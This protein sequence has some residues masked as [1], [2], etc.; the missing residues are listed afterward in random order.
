MQLNIKYKRGYAV[1]GILITLVITAMLFMGIGI[2][3]GSLA[4]H[5]PQLSIGSNAEYAAVMA[6][7]SAIYGTPHEM[8]NVSQGLQENPNTL[9]G[10]VGW[11]NAIPVAFGLI[12]FIESFFT[13]I[14]MMSGLPIAWALNFVLIISVVIIAFSI[15][16]F[17]RGSVRGL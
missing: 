6:N 8:Q 17:V 14:V 3:F 9:T 5:Y 7:A 12:N 4:T 16:N 10:T 15:I 1:Q 2:F 13:A 11:S